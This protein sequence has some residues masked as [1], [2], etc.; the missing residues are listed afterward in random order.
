MIY[1]GQGAYAKNN[2]L[3]V[4]TFVMLL[5]YMIPSNLSKADSFPGKKSN[6]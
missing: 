5:Q 3:N 4:T 1:F 2:L 6:L